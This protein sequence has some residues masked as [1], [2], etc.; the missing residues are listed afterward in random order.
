MTP[1]IQ[2]PN[3]LSFN[4]YAPQEAAQSKSKSK[5][6]AGGSELLLHSTS[7]RSLD[8]TA[9]EEGARTSK[10]LLN[11]YIGVYDPRTGK[12]QVVEAKKMVVR[13]QVR[14]KETE[15]EADLPQKVSSFECFRVALDYGG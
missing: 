6:H 10:P 13:P 8:Y 14:A 5:K 11:H 3:N 7:H 1:G 12:M 9:R 2:I 4:S 15:A